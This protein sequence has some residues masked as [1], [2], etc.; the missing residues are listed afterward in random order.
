M[1]QLNRVVN[2]EAQNLRWAFTESYDPNHQNSI[3]FMANDSQGLEDLKFESQLVIL[4]LLP[5][6]WDLRYVFDGI[7]ST[8]TTILVTQVPILNFDE[9]GD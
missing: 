6:V 8:A 9:V 3:T 7:M 2:F 1:L 5:G 4:Y